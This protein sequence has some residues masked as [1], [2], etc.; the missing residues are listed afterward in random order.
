MFTVY[1]HNLLLTALYCSFIPLKTKPMDI[2]R[3]RIISSIILTVSGM[4]LAKIIKQLH[5]LAAR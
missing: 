5:P 3:M 4:E 2:I 1:A